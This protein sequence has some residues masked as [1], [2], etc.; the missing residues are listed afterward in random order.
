M[1]LTGLERGSSRGIFDE[2][3]HMPE[4]VWALTAA[5]AADRTP[6]QTLTTVHL[7]VWSPTI[8]G[9]APA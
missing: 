7:L 9:K 1:C 6:R 2:A 5:A 3:A 4:C 8:S